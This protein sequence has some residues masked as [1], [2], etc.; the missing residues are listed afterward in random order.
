MRELLRATSSF[1]RNGRRNCLREIS[2]YC[3]ITGWD[4]TLESASTWAREG[5]GEDPDLF[6]INSTVYLS[7][8]GSTKKC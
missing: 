8:A 7:H 5:G 4:A 1:L 3:Q 2:K 6:L